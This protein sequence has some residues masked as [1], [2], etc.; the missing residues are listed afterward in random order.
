MHHHVMHCASFPCYGEFMT[1]SLRNLP[2][3]VEKAI[4]E[5]SRREGISINKATLRLLE[6]QLRKP[7]RNSDFEEFCGTWSSAEADAFD[8]ALVEMRRVDPADWES[9]G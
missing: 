5:T 7:A 1:I 4:L 3:E 6:A 9:A 2:M 8:A